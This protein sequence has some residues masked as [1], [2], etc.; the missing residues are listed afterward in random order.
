ME[1]I[2]VRLPIR[3]DIHPEQMAW[4]KEKLEEINEPIIIVSHQP[5][6]GEAAIN[7]A[8]DIQELL[9]G[10]S[11][12]ILLA[13]NGHSH[14]NCLLR[15][16]GISYLHV[17]S[18][19]YFWVGDKYVHDTYPKELLREYRWLSHICPYKDSLFAS[20]TIDPDT[21]NIYIRGSRSEWI[22][23]SPAALGYTGMPSATIGEEIS[24]AISDRLVEKVRRK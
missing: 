16:S 6:A 10:Y 11:N 15:V 17:N 23:S 7:N 3:E 21:L 8:G 19:S 1:T 4:L 22:G 18:A 13:I 20:M 14:I 24:P 5:L 2:K 9:S 12:K